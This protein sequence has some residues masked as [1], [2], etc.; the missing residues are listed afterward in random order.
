[1]SNSISENILTNGSF[2]P[3]IF[4]R[5]CWPQTP[6]N[7]SVNTSCIVLRHPGVDPSS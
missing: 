2:C 4:G 5:F 3:A 7:Q 1:M 6:A